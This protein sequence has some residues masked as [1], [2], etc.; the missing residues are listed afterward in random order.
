[1]ANKRVSELAQIAVGELASSDLLLVSDVSAQE[2]K[3]LTLGDLNSYILTDGNLSG[4]FYG[5][6]SWSEQSKTASFLLGTIQSASFAITAS[7][8][9]NGSTNAGSASWASSSLSSSF[10]TS[11]SFAQTVRQAATASF[12]TSSKFADSAS[13]VIYSGTNNGTIQNAINATSATNATSASFSANAFSSSYAVTAS[14]ALVT[15]SASFAQNSNTASYAGFAATAS[16]GITTNIQASAS[17]ASSS[18]SASYA[19]YADEAG[20]AI[21]ASYVTPNLSLQQYGIF[22]AITQSNYRSQLDKVDLD[23]FLDVPATASIEVAG[24]MVAPYT[25]SIP[26]NESVTLYALNRA[27]GHTVNLDSTPIYVN[28]QGQFSNISASIAATVAGNLNGSVTGSAQGNINNGQTTGS[29]SGSIVGQFT[30]SVSGSDAFGDI[31]GSLTSSYSGNLSGQF[32][33]SVTSSINAAYSGFLT[34]SITGSVSTLLSGSMKIPFLLM[35]Q[36]YL[37]S[38]SYMF[39]VSAS[40]SKIYIEPTRTTRFSVSSNIGEFGV[41]S[42]EPIQLV[43]DNTAQTI[44]FSSSAGGPFTDTAANIVASASL[45]DNILMVDISNVS[46][47]RYIWTL[48]SLTELKSNNNIFL[49]DIQGM[50]ASIVSMSLQSGVLNTLYDLSGSAC[51]YLNVFNNQLSSLGD[52]P[53]TMSYINC[54][55]NPIIALPSAVPAGV[56]HLFCNNTSISSPPDSFPTTV[57]SMSFANNNSLNLWLSTLPSAL[58]SFDVS[59]CPSLT[60]LPTIPANVRTLNVSACSF[61]DVAQDN[62]CSNLVTN[63]LTSGSLNLLGNASLLPITVT[64]IATLQ[65]RAWSVSY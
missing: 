25:S 62:I 14:T 15:T 20:T 11:A 48:T 8:A 7:Y 52:L 37:E 41:N 3:K 40:T 65:S 5:T 59:S 29:L 2:S 54:S 56:V 51:S 53:A 38:G 17:W 21:S 49:N 31:T 16:I 55:S 24:T 47:I 1:M 43:T 30:G 18:V 64:R 61:T 45:G 63:G 32:T 42:G 36:T 10:A 46:S 19:S 13:F 27:T 60:A 22:L 57:V 28:I 26:L 33:G 12:A 39:Y 44:N 9:L 4:S 23:P 58:A 50:P 34:G 6:A 35:G